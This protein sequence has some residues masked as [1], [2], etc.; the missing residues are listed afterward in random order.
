[1]AKDFAEW[2][3]QA[4]YDYET[5]RVM[6]QSGR[7][8][9]AVF[10]CHMAVEKALKALLFHKT[11]NVPPKTHNLFWLLSKIEEKPP[12]QIGEFIVKLNEANVATRYPEALKEMIKIYNNQIADA[13][14]TQTQET[15]SWIRSMQKTP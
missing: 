6:R 3:N 5:A 4:D 10:M 11:G 13:M 15:L 9:Y 12:Q 8:F 2:I 7:N 1:M 14:I